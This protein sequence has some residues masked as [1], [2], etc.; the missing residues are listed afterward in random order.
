MQDYSLFFEWLHHWDTIVAGAAALIA[1]L[2]TIEEMQEQ[3]RFEKKRYEDET[4]RKSL[5]A[6]A[7]MP[8]ALEELI[9]YTKGSFKYLLDRYG[10]G[11]P[12]TSSEHISI[13][14]EGL[15]F[16]DTETAEAIFETVIKYHTYTARLK[17]WAADDA[18]RTELI[19]AMKQV[20]GES[21]KR[22]LNKDELMYDCLYFYALLLNLLP[23]GRN[24]KRK[25]KNIIPSKQILINC[26]HDIAPYE[27][28]NMDKFAV[29]IDLINTR[30]PE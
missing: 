8:D 4:Y 16:V 18:I 7:K 13:L 20:E 17:E 12:N 14:K 1:A 3:L 28:L 10:H 2:M 21:T 27:A 11:C 6:R 30:H 29:L 26:L 25:A 9:N 19:K 24:E 23:Y 15:C 5:S 22:P